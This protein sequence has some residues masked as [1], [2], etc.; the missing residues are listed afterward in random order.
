MEKKKGFP[1]LIC[2]KAPVL[3]ML[4]GTLVMLTLC[5]ASSEPLKAVFGEKT[6]LFY[7]FDA[8]ISFAFMFLFKWWFRPDLKGIFKPCISLKEILVLL[9]PFFVYVAVQ[10]IILI[11]GGHI[12]FAPSFLNVCMGLDAGFGE[13]AMFRVAAVPIGLMYLKSKRKETSTII[14]S[15]VIFGLLHLLNVMGGVP[16]ASVIVQVIAAGFMGAFF[17]G[18]FMLSGSILLPV[19]AHGLWDYIVFTFDESVVGGLMTETTVTPALAIEVVLD[20][21][22]GVVTIIMVIKNKD[23]IKR[24]WDEKW[25]INEA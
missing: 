21:I 4:L 22:L 17:A 2:E 9:I 7:L 15:A 14:I 8:L 16:L 11:A 18:I 3:G 6:A 10:F 1:H 24:I 5:T 12:T 19:F 20:F 13:E 25:S 23:K